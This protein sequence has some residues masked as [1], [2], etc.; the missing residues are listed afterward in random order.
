VQ[1]LLSNLSIKEIMSMNGILKL[2]RVVLASLAMAW[3]VGGTVACSDS[4][5]PADA[6]APAPDSGTP[7]L[8]AGSPDAAAPGGDAAVALSLYERLGGKTGLEG[9][10]K[11]VVETK[12]LADA[13]LKTFFFNQVASPIPAGHPSARQ[14][15]VCFARLVATV[16]KADTYPGAPVNDPANSG[17]PNHT[18]RDMVSAHKSAGTMLNIGSANFDKF[19]GYIA[20]AL[21]PLV[22]PTATRAGEITQAEFDALAAA[23][24]GQK[25]DVTTASAPASGPYLPVLYDRLGGQAGLEAFV[26]GVVDN[27]ILTDANLKTFFFNQVASPIPAGHPSARQIEVCFARFV[28]AALQADTYPGTPVS[29]PANTNSPSFT[30]RDM[31]TVHRGAS[32]MLHIGS[33]TFDKFISYVA[34]DLM[35]LVKPTATKAGEIT[36][37]EFDALAAALN[38][39]KDAVTTAG[40]SATLGPFPN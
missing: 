33:G 37:A 25:S 2:E 8:D 35:P 3:G 7:R 10:V 14:I 5:S 9:F 15:E 19:V 11:T 26:K 28:G 39:Q 24:T 4:N 27:H 29:D 21:M 20:A 13:D 40:A 17:T 18:C 23:L 1:S 6:S 30:C 34:M 22:K 32:T 31:V 36:Q 38:G 16:L 12:I